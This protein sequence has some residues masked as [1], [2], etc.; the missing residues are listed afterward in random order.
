MRTKVTVKQVRSPVA[1]LNAQILKAKFDD[2]DDYLDA[3][4]VAVYTAAGAISPNVS[5]AL[6]DASVPRQ[7]MTLADG[8]IANEQILLKLRDRSTVAAVDPAG[9][10]LTIDNHELGTGAGPFWISSSTNQLP[11]GLHAETDYY[12][13]DASAYQIKLATSR[14]LANAGTAV[15]VTSAGAGT[16]TLTRVSPIDAVVHGTDEITIATHGFATGDGP[17]QIGSTLAV[18]EPL[19]KGTDYWIIRIDDDTI[20]LAA[21]ENDA[22]AGTQINLTANGTG[23]LFLQELAYRT[24][25]AA[26]GSARVAPANFTGGTYLDLDDEGDRA[27]L[28]WSGTAWAAKG[29]GTATV[30]GEMTS[31]GH[32]LVTG[33]GPFYI[34]ATVTIPTGLAALTPYWIIRL[35]V[36]KFLLA[37]SAD[38]AAGLIPVTVTSAGAGTITL[39]RLIEAESIDH[40]NDYLTIPGHGFATGDGPFYVAATTTIPTGL[41]A[42]TDYYAI[43]IDD[44]RL[45]VATSNGN[46]LANTFVNL[47]TPGVGVVSISPVAAITAAANGTEE[48]TIVGHGFATGDGP[49]RLK[50]ADLPLN[51]LEATDYWIIETGADTFQLATTHANAIALTEVTFDDDGSGAM[52]LYTT[53]T[54]SHTITAAANATDRLTSVAHGF[55]TGDGPIVLKGGDLPLNLVA[56]TL[57]WVIR[58]TDDIFKVATSEDNALAGTAVAFDDDG[59]GTMELWEP[60]GLPA[61]DVND[62]GNDFTITAHGIPDEATVRVEAHNGGALPT[63]L[64]PATTYYA[65]VGADVNELQVASSQPNAAANTEIQLTAAATLP[66]RVLQLAYKTITAIDPVV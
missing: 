52:V 18:P 36:D 41:A 53:G 13:I 1:A 28:V 23:D 50:G 40:W 19:T 65:I 44:D 14:L 63:G 61:T 22:L 3:A 27:R 12:I 8:T 9:D 16:I 21:D 43:R 58:V 60:G 10:T 42:L 29:T 51:L 4:G 47:T 45:Q 33:D 7:A 11:G 30:G 26:N 38:N 64:L 24:V 17:V 6:I 56:G 39:T 25:A 55:V 31:V 37:S 57:Y 49:V 46:A 34:D 15:D 66:V 32:G 20:Q 48:L 5:L 54:N 59:S 62:L 35:T 2:F